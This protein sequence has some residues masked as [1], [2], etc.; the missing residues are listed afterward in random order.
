M[1]QASSTPV[2]DDLT[3]NE[4]TLAGTQEDSQEKLKS[5]LKTIDKHDSCRTEYRCILDFELANLKYLNLV[6]KCDTCRTITGKDI[7]K[8]VNCRTCISKNREKLNTFNEQC[9]KLELSK[10]YIN[11]YINLAIIVNSY[12]NLC[13][14]IL[15]YLFGTLKTTYLTCAKKCL[16]IL[17]FGSKMYNNKHCF[18]KLLIYFVIGLYYDRAS[19][20]YHG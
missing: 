14:C 10:D 4:Y 5:I 20:S 8:T 17:N 16:A 6:N 3:F 11:F 18:S 1:R 19:G 12:P 9:K 2:C 15:R 7:L 13:L